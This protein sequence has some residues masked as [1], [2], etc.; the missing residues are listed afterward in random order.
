[1][2]TKK[3][4]GNQNPFS[5]VRDTREVTSIPISPPRKIA[6]AKYAKPLPIDKSVI[7]TKK[8]K[9]VEVMVGITER[10]GERIISVEITEE[11]KQP[12]RISFKT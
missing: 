9:P 11:G 2:N 8:C 10:N 6:D 1:M 4:L 3:R 5:W 12:T 7:Q